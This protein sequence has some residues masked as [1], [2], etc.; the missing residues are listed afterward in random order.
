MNHLD[1]LTINAI[2]DGEAADDHVRQCAQCAA[3]VLDVVRLKGAIRAL[4][5]DVLPLARDAARPRRPGWCTYTYE[6]EQ[7]PE[8]EI[9]CGGVNSKTPRAGAVWRQGHLLHFGFDLAPS[10]LTDAGRALLVNSIAYVARFT[11]DRPIVRTPSVFAAVIS[12]LLGARVQADA[13]LHNW[14]CFAAEQAAQPRREG[15][16]ARC[17]AGAAGARPRAP[18]PRG[19]RRERRRPADRRSLRRQ[20]VLPGGARPRARLPKSTCAVRKTRS[21]A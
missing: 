4:S 16:P 9:L 18:G 19:A 1:E 11:E 2:A 17:R 12:A 15:A 10:E 21:A 20:R 5:V 13:S 3:A 8:L 6:H 7:A 14:A